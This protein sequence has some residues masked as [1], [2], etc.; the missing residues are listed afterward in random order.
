MKSG[1]KKHPKVYKA[2]IS[3]S[4]GIDVIDGV[5]ENLPCKDNSFDFALMVTTCCQHFLEKAL[6]MYKPL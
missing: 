5:A 6:K 4:K 3:R 2:E 1:L